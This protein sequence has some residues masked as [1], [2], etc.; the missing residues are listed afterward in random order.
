MA[1]SSEAAHRARRPRGRSTSTDRADRGAPGGKGP[2]S[3]EALRRSSPRSVGAQSPILPGTRTGSARKR[4]RR[5][6]G[7]ERT[8]TTRATRR[9]I[10]TDSPAP[11]SRRPP[12]P[13]D[14]SRR[15]RPEAGSTSAP[16]GSWPDRAAAPRD[17]VRGSFSNRGA[18]PLGLP[19]TLIRSPLRRLAPFAW[20]TRWRSFALAH[21]ACCGLRMDH[22][23]LQELDASCAQG[24]QQL[25]GGRRIEPGIPRFNRDEEAVVG[26]PLED[27][28][29]EERMVVHGEP[30][31]AEHAEDG[32]E[33]AE[34]NSELEGDRNEGR[35]AEERLPADH[36]GVGG[37]VDPRLQAEPERGPRQSHD[38]DDPG[39]L[40]APESHRSVEA[41][42]GERAVSVPP[43][44]ACVTHPLAG[45]IEVRRRR[46]RGEGSVI[47]PL[48]EPRDQRDLE[49][50]SGARLRAVDTSRRFR[51]RQGFGGPP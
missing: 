39:K 13:A 44:E 14:C 27:P 34:E 7:S 31:Q 5:G 3:R 25:P 19:Y 12:P 16:A 21:S 37:S 46:E 40:G 10:A 17:R 41:V 32:A 2:L 36:K 18:S 8:G 28:G 35:P 42:D 26:H 50:P 33:R 9:R 51:L 45:V 48:R 47:R 24:L 43:R 29:S 15:Q 30:V 20:L 4:A 23:G 1:P 11:E 22:S 6:S 38:E 49:A